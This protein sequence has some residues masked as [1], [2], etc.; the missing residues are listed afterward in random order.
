MTEREAWLLLATHLEAIGMPWHPS[1]FETSGLCAGINYMHKDGLITF[2]V[3]QSMNNRIDRA[4]PKNSVY[5]ENPDAAKPR[6]KW[7]LKFAEESR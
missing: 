1:G 4:L 7:C 3:M 6:V 5:L 2:S